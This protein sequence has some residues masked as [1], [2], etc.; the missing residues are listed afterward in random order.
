[1]R[2]WWIRLAAGIGYIATDSKPR[3]EQHYIH[4]IEAAA[5]LKLIEELNLALRTLRNESWGTMRCHA[6]AIGYDHGNSNWAC[7]ERSW[8]IADQA[9]AKAQAFLKQLNIPKGE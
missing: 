6:V 9:L 4:V 8:E 5:A 1:M 7:L 2:Q 3:F